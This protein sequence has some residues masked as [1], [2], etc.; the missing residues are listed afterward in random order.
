MIKIAEYKHSKQPCSEIYLVGS[1]YKKKTAAGE[2][3]EFQNMSHL[4]NS[5]C[6]CMAKISPIRCK[7]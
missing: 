5:S 7:I 3:S 6:R 4:N 1:K 2:S